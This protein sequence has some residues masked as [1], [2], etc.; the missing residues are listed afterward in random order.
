[1]IKFLGK[2]L[3]YFSRG[4]GGV[5]TEGFVVKTRVWLISVCNHGQGRKKCWGER[6]GPPQSVGTPFGER[7]FSKG[8]GGEK[9][10][11]YRKTGGLFGL[12]ARYGLNLITVTSY[13]HLQLYLKP[14]PI[15]QIENY[16]FSPKDSNPEKRF[17]CRSISGKGKKKFKNYST[18]E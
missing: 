10:D 11:G 9:G 17:V 8:R 1:M 6:S 12:R 15:V 2:H 3:T 13:N 14:L 5:M 18:S 7:R 16:T 4:H